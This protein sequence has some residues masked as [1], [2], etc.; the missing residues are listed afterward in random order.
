MSQMA[1]NFVRR[2][3]CFRLPIAL[4]ISI[5]CLLIAIAFGISFERAITLG[6][7][8]YVP[9]S[10]FEAIPP[11]IS[12][13]IFAHDKKYTSLTTVNEM[14][15]SDLLNQAPDAE[16]INAS[17]AHIVNSSPIGSDRSY[18]LMGPDDKGMVDFVTI[19]FRLFGLEVQSTLY[20]FFLI[21][22]ISCCCFILG[23]F[24]SSSSLLLLMAF[25]IE[26]YLVL[27]MIA[28]NPQ[29]NS[30]LSYRALPILSMVACL[31]CLLFALLDCRSRYQMVLVSTLESVTVDDVVLLDK[32]PRQSLDEKLLEEL[33]LRWMLCKFL[34][35]STVS[36]YRVRPKRESSCAP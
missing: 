4:S 29:L 31:H 18:Q 14:F 35:V 8:K 24:R 34:S 10:V 16:H 12:N 23:F 5:S 32:L 28:F 15:R 36:A 2:M 9:V 3:L 1:L 7:Q 33:R 13:L 22:F 30:V 26:F 20:L 19:A 6:M 17:I 27:P 25:L 11:A 21:L